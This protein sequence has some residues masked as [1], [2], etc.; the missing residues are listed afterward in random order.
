MARVERFEWLGA[1]VSNAEG[2]RMKAVGTVLRMPRLVGGSAQ[3]NLLIIEPVRSNGGDQAKHEPCPR[4]PRP[5][6][7]WN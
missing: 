1:G 3:A 2:V 7:P 4:G 6:V 5:N